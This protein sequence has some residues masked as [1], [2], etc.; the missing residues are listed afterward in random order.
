MIG[1]I[2]TDLQALSDIND[3]IHEALVNGYPGY[4]ATA[5]CQ[6][7]ANYETGEYLLILESEGLAYELALG[8]LTEEEKDLIITVPNDWW[9]DVDPFL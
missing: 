1:I 7:N 5:Y 4:A 3:K 8:A 6:C 9:P 2:S